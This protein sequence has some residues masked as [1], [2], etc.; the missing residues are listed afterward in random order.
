MAFG[1]ILMVGEEHRQGLPVFQ[2]GL[3]QLALPSRQAEPV[4]TRHHG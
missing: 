4:P 3:G 1:D 2:R